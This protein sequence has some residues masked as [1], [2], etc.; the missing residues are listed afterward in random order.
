MD[1]FNE[2]L[3]NFD[4]N[5]FGSGKHKISIEKSL[6]LNRENKAVLLDVRTTQEAE[7][8]KFGFALNIP[9]SEIPD[10]INEIPTDKTIIIFCVSGVRAVMIYTYL[11]VIGDYD[12]KILT[13]NISE[14]AGF[15]K[16]GYLLKNQGK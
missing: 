14:I 2:L 3:K 13:A 10:R 6:E 7:Q 8:V 15:F 4:L 1:K 16:P 12:V 9:V 5:F 11:K